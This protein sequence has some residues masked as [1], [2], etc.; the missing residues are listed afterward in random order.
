MTDGRANA[1]GERRKTAMTRLLRFHIAPI[2]R[3]YLWYFYFPFRQSSLRLVLFARALIHVVPEVDYLDGK[4]RKGRTVG[5]ICLDQYITAIVFHG[6]AQ[7]IVQ[8]HGRRRLTP[9]I[10]YRVTFGS[11]IDRPCGE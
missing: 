10:G 9:S 1:S 8:Y 2:S 11:L 4:E 6:Q 3:V 7:A 5:T